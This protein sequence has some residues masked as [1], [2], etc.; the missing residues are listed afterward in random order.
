MPLFLKTQIVSRIRFG[1]TGVVANFQVTIT[2]GLEGEGRVYPASPLFS[3]C[4]ESGN[5]K[6]R[7]CVRQKLEEAIMREQPHIRPR[8]A[9]ETA[10]NTYY[11]WA[12]PQH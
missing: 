11:G 5:T 7:L 3:E 12:T 4:P 8:A 6:C 2:V 1:R 9:R 10:S